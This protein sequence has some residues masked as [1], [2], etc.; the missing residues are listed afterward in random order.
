MIT[1]SAANL[2]VNYAITRT[3]M[4]TADYSTLW[5]RIADMEME[6]PVP[7]GNGPV[8]MAV[9]NLPAEIP[10]E[11]SVF[12]SGALKA[13]MPGIAS[14][15][16]SGRLADCRLPDSVRRGLILFRGQFTPEYEYMK[17]FI[18]GL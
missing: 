2:T 5:W 18:K 6:I 9:D 17:D 8:V 3:A 13:F 12:F 16:F 11:S 1:T 14:A 10:L 15:D 7:R 4:N